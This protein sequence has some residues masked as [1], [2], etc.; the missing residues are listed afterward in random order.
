MPSIIAILINNK[1]DLSVIIVSYNVSDLLR[2]CLRSVYKACENIDSEIFVIDNNSSDDSY[3]MIRREYPGIILISNPVNAGYAA[4]NNQA[5]RIARGKYALLLNPDT[6]VNMN[7]FALCINFMN[8]HID[9]G[10]L[11]VK[12]TDG[13][14]LYL[15]ESKRTLPSLSSTF[16]K[17][18]GLSRL[19]PDSK[20]FNSYYLTSVGNDETARTEVISGA[21]MFIRKEILGKTGLLDED[22]FMYGEDIDLSYRILKAGYH[23]YYYPS[24]EITHFKG[25]STARDNYEDILFFYKAMKIYV[26]KRSEEGVFTCPRLIITGIIFRESF[27]LFNRFLKIYRDR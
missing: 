2:N 17:S 7:S 20:K 16:S 8:S 1:M 6:L 18:F 25:R 19:F 12:M 24:V 21:F 27:A 4:A 11:G 26:R 5:L 13:A 22:Y 10:A 9:A 3:S 15:P 14:G 23:N